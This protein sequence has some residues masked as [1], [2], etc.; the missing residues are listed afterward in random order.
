MS[1]YKDAVTIQGI[2][3]AVGAINQARAD[4]F[5]QNTLFQNQN[6]SSALNELTEARKFVGDPEHILGSMATKHGEVAEHLEVN[7][8]NA[9]DLVVGKKTSYTFEGVG[10]TA[11][12]DYLKN[13]LPVQSKFVQSN[14]SM[15]AVLKHLDNYPNFVQDGGTYC[16]P[17]DY[18]EKIQEW[19]KLSPKELSNLPASEEGNVARAVIDKIKELE[20]TTGKKFNEIVE[21]SQLEYGQVQLKTANGTIDASEQ[22][23]IDI[24]AQE[25]KKY[26][27]MSKASLKEGLKTAGIAAAISGVLSFGTSLVSTLKAQKKKLSELTKEDWAE[28]FKQTGL[29]AVKG[30]VTGGSIYALTNLAQMSAP[31]AAALVSATL[32]VASQ[33]IRLYK[34]EISFDD[35]M[36]NIAECAV[37]TAVSAVGAVVGQLL[38][39]V[40]VLGAVVGSIVSTTILG[41]VKRHLFGWGYYELFKKAGYE[42]EYSD[43]Y[44]PLTAAF[45]ECSSTFNE[46][47]RI[48]TA[49]MGE[50]E[51]RQNGSYSGDVD[52]KQTLD[53]ILNS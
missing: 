8:G 24:D 32:G 27:E 16:I 51:E 50:L 13:G 3:S 11:P 38:I 37:D 26:L 34:K 17:K 14:L 5:I 9:K 1:Y 46:S 36:C 28:I 29:D 6:L 48:Y 2:G 39:P 12:E 22:E 43:A 7:I 44:L 21:P 18:Y 41:L 35:F 19:M 23:I 33:A 31:L 10:R 4:Q 47:L 53:K 30:G 15:D 49:N 52:L 25:R 42:K 20:N 40:P 45:D